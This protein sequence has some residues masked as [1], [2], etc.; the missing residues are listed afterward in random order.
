MVDMLIRG[1]DPDVARR[2]IEK[3]A[4]RDM[5]LS[6]LAREAI[7]EYVKPSETKGRSAADAIRAKIGKLSGDS[8]KGIREDRDNDEPYR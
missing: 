5:S 1:V 3:A 6:D 2:L 8:T 4:A 7:I